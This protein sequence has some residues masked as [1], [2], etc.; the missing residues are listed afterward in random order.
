[1]ESKDFIRINPNRFNSDVSPLELGP[2][3]LSY[4][5]N[6]RHRAGRVAQ[7]G[8]EA[9]F[10]TPA[11]GDNPHQIRNIKTQ[12]SQFNWVIAGGS[13]IKVS[14]DSDTVVDISPAG[15][16]SQPFEVKWTIENFNSLPV[17]NRFTD[18]PYY[19]LLD[20]ANP[21]VQLPG[22][23]VGTV[24]RSMRAYRNFLIALNI[25]DA[26]GDYPDQ[27]LWSNSADAGS[28]PPDW[29]ISDPGSLAGTT[30]LSDTRGE[31]IDAH[32][33]KNSLLIYKTN[34]VYRMDAIGG[35]FVFSLSLLFDSFG[36]ISP[37]CIVE[38]FNGHIVF[39]GTDLIFHD[40]HAPKS[41][42]KGR[43]QELFL[44]SISSEA[45]DIYKSFL[46]H[47]SERREVWLFYVRRGSTMPDAALVYSYVYDEISFLDLASD[48]YSQAYGL[49]QT[50][51]VVADWDSDNESWNSTTKIWNDKITAGDT[52]HVMRGISDDIVLADDRANP[53]TTTTIVNRETVII[54][55]EHAI[56][57]IYR[58]QLDILADHDDVELTFAL[59]TQFKPEDPISW[60]SPITFYPTDTTIDIIAKGRYF[61]YQITS[62][63]QIYWEL[64]GI[65][66]SVKQSGEY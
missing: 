33:L 24:C 39:S 38:I 3:F 27:I 46:F 61:S 62:D 57:M 5:I 66:I 40:G 22:W 10:L 54:P 41:L 9:D 45:E 7:I 31:I 53:V 32:I 36:A 42:L 25:R 49:I 21:C 26:T 15:I 30:Q 58:I 6:I 65:G 44:E 4:V 43:A 51:A 12:N 8:G 1:M 20:T 13:S 59:G 50:Q 18:P 14:P 19:W 2:E 37:N 52:L 11:L 48:T 23:P 28:V 29:D 16:G 63:S 34:S 55:P 17:F 56:K 35:T 64:R 47:H 60:K